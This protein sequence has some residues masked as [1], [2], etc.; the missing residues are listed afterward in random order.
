MKLLMFHAKEF[1]Y[2]P[3]SSAFTT[4]KTN[5]ENC[6]II[7]IH[8]EEIDKDKGDVIGKAVGNRK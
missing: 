4:E 3:Y 2:K 5:F 8:V 1:W 6:L 7:F